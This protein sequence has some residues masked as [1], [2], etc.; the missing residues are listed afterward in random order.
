MLRIPTVPYGV[1]RPRDFIEQ[2]LSRSEF[3]SLVATGNLRLLR[4]G[5]YATDAA[6]PHVHRAVSLGGHLSCLSALQLAGLWMPPTIGLHVR[7]ARRE[8]PTRPEPERG[9]HYC[10]GYGPEAR[11]ASGPVDTA[12]VALTAA[13]RCTTPEYLVAIM[14]CALHQHKCTTEELRECLAPCPRRIR[15]LVDRTAKAESGT[16]SLVRFRLESA[17]IKVHP[18]VEIPGVGRVDLVVGK[19]LVIEVDSFAHHTG[20]EAYTR[21]R[22]RDR[23][24][25]ALGYERIRLTYEQ[26]MFDWDRVFSDILAIIRRGEHLREPFG[27]A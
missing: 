18:Q 7:F 4:H 5:W 13:A 27:A 11:R 8:S 25:A 21:D 9:V 15:T 24:L 10:T 20:T 12:W 19:R 1:A 22:E 3:D 17:R 16:E 6:H 14:D 23:V 2:G 26:V